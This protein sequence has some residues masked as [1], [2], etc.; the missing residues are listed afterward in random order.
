M[1]QS[2]VVGCSRHQYLILRLDLTLKVFV[3]RQHKFFCVVPSQYFDYAGQNHIPVAPCD[4][5]AGRHFK[6]PQRA[7]RVDDQE[8]PS[9]HWSGG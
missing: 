4:V 2:R 1:V 9:S 8:A 5:V 7:S 3:E 6:V